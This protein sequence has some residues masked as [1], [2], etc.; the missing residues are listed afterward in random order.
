MGISLVE[1]LKIGFI[2]TKEET[3]FITSKSK[4]K[5]EKERWLHMKRRENRYKHC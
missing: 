4:H 5:G 1:G 3:V 2:K